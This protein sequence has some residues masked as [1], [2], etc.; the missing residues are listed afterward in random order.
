MSQFCKFYEN[1]GLCKRIARILFGV[2][3]VAIHVSEE[4]EI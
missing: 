1:I 3:E 4:P 2:L